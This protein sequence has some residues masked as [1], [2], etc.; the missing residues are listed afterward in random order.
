MTTSGCTIVFYHYVRNVERTPFPS[1]KGLSVDGF[2]AQLDWLQARYDVIDGGSFERAVVNGSLFT[3]PT[4]LLT[5]DDG[6]IDH[7]EN[8]FPILR[9]RK[10]GGIF[11]I[12]GATLA[13]R[14]VLLNV[15]KTHFLLARLGADRFASEVGDALGREGVDVHSRTADESS[16]REG[17]TG[18]YRYDEAPETRIKRVL[19]YDAPHPVADRVLTALFDRHIG[20][21]V[22]FA[23]GLYL[24]SGQ[25]GE[26]ARGEIGRAH[27]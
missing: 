23:R 17:R 14:P 22:D 8:V 27:V 9:A 1:I 12:A 3:R 19:N 10:L 7:F 4:A 11:F 2:V 21:S 26:M 13:A 25:I 6:F 20:D 18:I 15:H 24:T 5:F 16:L